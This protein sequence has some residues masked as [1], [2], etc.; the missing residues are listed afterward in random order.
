MPLKRS[1]SEAPLREA[2]L[3][4]LRRRHGADPEALIVEE[5]GVRHGSARVDVAVINGRLDGYELK[6]KADTLRRLP[7]QVSLY[8]SVLDTVTL[9][10]DHSHVE[11]GSA[12][13]PAWWGIVASQ[14]GPRGGVKFQFLRR[15]AQ[16]P[17]VD[18]VS[19]AKLLW[20]SEALHLLER[21][22]AAQ[23]VRSAPRKVLY[24]R[25][26]ARL[27]TAQL[28]DEVRTQLRS[29]SAWRSDGP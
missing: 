9:V 20:R 6:S 14:V 12:L 4:H 19:V 3:R 16:N 7:R 27:D 29:R 25:L 26:V 15:A 23:G 5:L 24:E 10:C 21:H 17:S 22:H 8:G 28:K 18:P 11:K 1:E 2:L 13:I